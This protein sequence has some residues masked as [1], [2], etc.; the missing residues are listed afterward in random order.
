[1]EL[2]EDLLKID[3]Q[4]FK[5]KDLVKLAMHSRDILEVLETKE[6]QKKIYNFTAI[7]RSTHGAWNT[8]KIIAKGY[9]LKTLLKGVVKNTPL[10]NIYNLLDMPNQRMRAKSFIND[11]SNKYSTTNIDTFIK[12]LE[13]F[14][15]A[16]KEL[17]VADDI[18]L[19]LFLNYI[20]APKD[21]FY[22]LSKDRITYFT[23]IEDSIRL[24]IYTLDSNWSV[25]IT[26]T[27]KKKS[28]IIKIKSQENN[29][30]VKHFWPEEIL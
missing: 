2:V 7:V 20:N 15:Q 30:L 27:I 1:M 21:I 14:V 9:D 17:E 10:S 16:S 23:E 4:N 18:K 13:E 26:G 29:T 25:S 6:Y 22:I 5:A 8:P 11:S 24:T 3:Y 19:E 28:S 12:T